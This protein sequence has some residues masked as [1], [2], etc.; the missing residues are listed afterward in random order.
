MKTSRK[1]DF[2]SDFEN[3]L[4]GFRKQLY[5]VKESEEMII[6]QL[7]NKVGEKS[8]VRVM[9]KDGGALAGDDYI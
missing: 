6:I 2:N 8:R 3:K 5:K 1:N 7:C 4:F 9:T